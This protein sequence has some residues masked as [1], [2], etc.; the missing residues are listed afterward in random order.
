MFTIDDEEEQQT[1]EFPAHLLDQILENPF[2][3]DL[4]K[5]ETFDWE[6]NDMLYK[7]NQNQANPY[8]GFVA[9]YLSEYIRSI[10]DHTK[11]VSDCDKVYLPGR[12]NQ[13]FLKRLLVQKE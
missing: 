7:N 9:G 3:F 11:M 12:F 10:C 5:S 2:I 6:V 4:I 8:L 1:L 13:D